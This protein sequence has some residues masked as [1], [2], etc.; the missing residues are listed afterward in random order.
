MEREKVYL[1]A[2]TV[3]NISKTDMWQVRGANQQTARKDLTTSLRGASIPNHR[4]NQPKF[5][6]NYS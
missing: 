2:G 4:I 1:Q 5:I 3:Y 6:D